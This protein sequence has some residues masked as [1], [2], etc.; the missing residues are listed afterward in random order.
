[1]AARAG[2]SRATAARALGSYGYASDDVRARVVAA[3]AELGYR[4]NRAARTMRNG[5]TQMVG[6]IC[7]D[8]A[9]GVFSSAMR[10][11]CDVMEPADYQVLVVNSDERPEGERQGVQALL[12]H[13]VDGMIV[14]PVLTTPTDPLLALRAKGVLVTLDRELD[15]VP[16]VVAD[17]RASARTAVAR[18]IDLGHRRVA[19]LASVQPDEPVR[20]IGGRRRPHFT[21]AP[22]PSTARAQGYHD[23]L[24]AAGIGLDPDLVVLR[25]RRPSEGQHDALAALVRTHGATALFTADSY[26]TVSAFRGLRELGCRVPED[27][28]LVGFSD[29]DWPD[30]VRPAITVVRQDAYEMGRRA[31]LALLQTMQGGANDGQIVVPTQTLE[32]NSLGPAPAR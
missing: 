12:A 1:M 29:A 25:S 31:A 2:V 26:Q 9:D 30:L 19:L 18:A 4:P 6:F 21:G 5:R 24:I 16:S 11:I 20:L 3:A 22:R 32:G 28:S 23:A 27:V 10:G 13:G 7:G 8:I 14:S 17:N 15:G